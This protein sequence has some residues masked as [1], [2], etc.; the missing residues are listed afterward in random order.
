MD[1]DP[2]NIRSYGITNNGKTLT[3]TSLSGW[4][5]G[6]FLNTRISEKQVYRFRVIKC[7]NSIMI[8]MTQDTTLNQN[9]QLG[10]S[11][12]PWVYDCY[13]GKINERGN[14]KQGTSKTP[15]GE[16]FTMSIN[17]L[18]ATLNYRK[19]GQE[20]YSP[21]TL[22]S[23]DLQQERPIAQIYAQGDSLEVLS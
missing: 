14:S 15:G 23:I 6:V 8:G 18:E 16:E 1:W 12:A 3:R 10:W 19:E 13:T 7:T 22:T 21:M 20:M 4:T 2:L 9:Q 5:E 17:L 11:I